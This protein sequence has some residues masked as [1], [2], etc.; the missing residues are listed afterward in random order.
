MTQSTPE[1]VTAARLQLFAPRC[2]YLRWA[3]ALDAAAKRYRIDT[4]RRVAHWL[5]QIHVESQGL[6]VF[7]ENLRYTTPS[8]L[9]AVFA[10]IRTDAE[11]AALI[12]KGPQA[13]ANKV[14]AGRNGNGNEAS[15]DGWRFRGMGPLQATGR[16]NYRKGGIWTGL[17]LEA[18][19]ELLLIPANGAR[20]AAAYWNV[21]DL[22]DEADAGDII[23]ITRAINGPALCGLSERKRETARA[24]TIWKP[25]PP[26]ALAA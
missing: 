18:D 3:P 6:T 8:R 19:P 22:N 12:R 15:G 2:D 9:N 14:Y 25:A 17:D 20:Y 24:L 16:G 5:A 4:P 11:A 21:C 26:A 13:I 23:E 7:E 1:A 10:A